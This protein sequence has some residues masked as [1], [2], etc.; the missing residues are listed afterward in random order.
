M[1][2]PLRGFSLRVTLHYLVLFT[3]SVLLLGLAWWWFTIRT[4]MQEVS[5]QVSRE[6]AELVA[7]AAAV[8]R[9][10]LVR[11]L[12]AR[13][14]A[15]SGRMPFHAYV[16]ADGTLINGNLPSWPATFRSGWQ[17]IEADLYAD[18]DEVDHEAL[19][20]DH[21]FP[22]GTRLMT[23]RDIED[24]DEIEEKLLTAVSGLLTGTLLL[25]V[26]G[27]LLMNR[28][29]GGRI[30]AVT[31]TARQ[32][33]DGDLSGRIPV[34][35]TTD[36][37]DQLNA[38]LNDM[39]ARTERLF[40]S[41]RRVSDNVA[42]ELRTPLARLRASLEQLRTAERTTSPAR[43]DEAIEE[44][45]SLEKTF[46]A[47]LRIARIESGRHSTGMSLVNLSTLLADAVE[48]Y[49]PLAEERGQQLQAEI[50]PALLVNGD[51][52]LL[53]QSACNLLDNAVKYAPSRGHI[54]LAARAVDGHAELTVT[55]DG[56]GVAA[57]HLGRITERFYRVPATAAR[58]GAGLGLSLVAAVAE[59]HD[60]RL[61]FHDA[62]PGLLVR[63][64]LPLKRHP[65][66]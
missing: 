52:D 4:P 40:D 10:E 61:T 20:L 41:V 7:L 57:E 27:G 29:I 15:P 28:A 62:T 31:R 50:A 16:A 3:L 17:R 42:H 43:L 46:E 2:N 6:H 21:L 36:D 13:A 19:T 5:Q 12:E 60:S 34:R 54:C 55:D 35:G 37:F 14:A 32:V 49:L 30:A 24:I 18:G 64:A 39:L 26:V 45:V 63:W 58:P 44:A 66:G 47:V 23:G 9:A 1:M 53:F 38:T 22:D 8:D 48:L 56:P 59:R 65:E 33:M 11:K 51:R 25:G